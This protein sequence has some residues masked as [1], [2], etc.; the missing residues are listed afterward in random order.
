MNIIHFTL[1]S[2]NPESSNGVNRV[3]EGLSKYGNREPNIHIKVVTL[4]RKQKFKKKI[5]LRDGFQVYIFNSLYFVINY[6]RKNIDKIDIVHLHNV[7]SI[8]NIIIF[9][10]L[11]QKNI[12]VIATP[13]SGLSI[14]RLKNSNYFLKL[15][16]NKLIQNQYLNKLDG[17]HCVSN[18]EKNE[19]SRFTYNK[20][21]FVINNGIDIEKIELKLK[22]LKFDSSKKPFIYIGF[23]GRVEKEKNILAL[24]KALSLLDQNTLKK[25]K[26]LIIGGIKENKYGKQV[27]KLAKD[28]KVSNNIQFLGE[29]YDLE[30]LKIMK[31]LDIYLQ[32]SLNEGFSISIIEAMSLKLPIIA[33]KECKLDDIKNQSFIKLISSTPEHIAIGLTEAIKNIDFFKKSGLEASKYAKDNYN[34]KTLSKKMIK[35]YKLVL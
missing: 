1:G 7:F 27:I 6:L 20:N 8:P 24:I 15:L 18:E 25:I 19:L 17:I 9:Y 11:Y 30:L 5:Y 26:L 3:I 35:Q 12:K 13:H 32:P 31:S 21:I 10:F 4:N 14:N 23:L 22:F 16:F 29:K 33:T 2:L 28:L 34:W